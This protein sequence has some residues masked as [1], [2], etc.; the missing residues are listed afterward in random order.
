M[1]DQAGA[2]RD[3]YRR[4]ADSISPKEQVTDA[5]ADHS[6][7]VAKVAEYLT[8]GEREA[9][10][11]AL[12]RDMVPAE[13]LD[14]LRAEVSRLTTE[15]DEA[16]RQLDHALATWRSVLIS[17]DQWCERTQVAEVERDRLRPVVEAA[18]AWHV[19]QLREPTSED[20]L[21]AWFHGLE[22]AQARLGAALDAYVT[23]RPPSEGKESE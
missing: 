6:A 14:D 20:E 8:P 1:C 19:L 18:Q 11:R 4:L 7:L 12:E 17:R 10:L 13:E 3:S 5:A 22:V 15:R 23:V 9:W 16:R 2:T 21:W